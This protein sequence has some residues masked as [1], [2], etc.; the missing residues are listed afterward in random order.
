MEHDLWKWHLLPEGVQH[1]QHMGVGLFTRLV[2]CP[3]RREQSP[4]ERRVA[5]VYFDAREESN[6]KQKK[7]QEDGLLVQGTLYALEKTYGRKERRSKNVK[8][9]SKLT[10]YIE[11]SLKEVIIFFF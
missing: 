8:V 9:G 5:Q 3:Q 11:S 7:K 4:R 6:K 10:H 2:S 1:E